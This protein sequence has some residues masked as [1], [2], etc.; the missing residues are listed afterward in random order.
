MTREMILISFLTTL[1]ALMAISHQAHHIEHTNI[2]HLSGQR[3][4]LF[5]PFSF[6]I[7]QENMSLDEWSLF[8]TLFGGFVYIHARNVKIFYRWWT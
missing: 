3:V 2:F 4:Q 5:R 8:L 7:W 1:L 6:E